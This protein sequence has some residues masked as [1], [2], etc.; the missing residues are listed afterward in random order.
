MLLDITI[1]SFIFDI[2]DIY[3][4]FYNL[5]NFSNSAKCNHIVSHL[6]SILKYKVI[7]LV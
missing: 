3:H 7:L 2:F 5:L 1:L 4:S 6:I